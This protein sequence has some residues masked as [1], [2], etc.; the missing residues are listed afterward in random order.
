[1]VAGEV[2]HWIHVLARHRIFGPDGGKLSGDD[3]F[4]D[5]CGYELWAVIRDGSVV[6]SFKNLPAYKERPVVDWTDRDQK[7]IDA[8]HKERR[9]GWTQFAEHLKAIDVFEQRSYR[10]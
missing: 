5:R 6:P 9:E 1:M 2:D 4:W 10:I 7:A 3:P 8:Y